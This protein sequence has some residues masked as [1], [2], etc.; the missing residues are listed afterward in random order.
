[1]KSRHPFK[2]AVLDTMRFTYLFEDA[3]A[4]AARCERIFEALR[5][6]EFQGII[7]PITLA[8]VIVKPLRMN[9]PDIADRYRAA[10]ASFPNLSTCP[11]TPATAA[12]AG[13]LRG[14]YEHPL[15]DLFQVACAMEHNAALLTN[16]KALRKSLK[17][18][19]SC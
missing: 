11:I 7:T 1:M 5:R 10:L 13:A 15:P 6:G 3:L 2:T 14:K 12:M 18:L 19:S 16:D 9:R 17:S 8:E 4:H